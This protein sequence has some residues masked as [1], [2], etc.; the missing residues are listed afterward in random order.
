[1]EGGKSGAPR[2]F[3]A[4]AWLCALMLLVGVIPLYAISIYSHPHY[5]DYGF[6][7]NVHQAWQDTGNVLTLLKTAAESAA[8]VRQTWQG[9]YLGT[10][11]SNVQP[12]VFSESLYFLTTFILLTAFLLCFGYFFYTVLKVLFHAE[13]Y[14]ILCVAS[15]AMFLMLQLMPQI[16]EGLYWFN[17]G[18]GN[19]FVY[20]LIALSLALMIRLWFANG[21]RVWRLTAALALLM[22]ALGGGSY[23]GGLFLLCIGAM[24]ILFAFWKKHK[25]RFVVLGLFLVLAAGFLYSM[26]APGNDARAGIMGSRIS[27]PEAVLKSMYYGVTLLGSYLTLPVLAVMLFAVPLFWELAGKSSF[28]FKRPLAVLALGIGLFCTQLAPPIYSGV[29][30]GGGRIQNTY[31]FSFI[32]MILL[33]ELYLLGYL[34]KKLEK[35]FAFTEKMKRGIAVLAAFLFVFGVLGFSRTTDGTFG[36]KNLTGVEAAVSIFSGE[37]QAYDAAMDAREALLNDP[38]LPYVVLAP[39]TSTPKTFMADTLSSDMTVSILR[40]LTLYYR[41]QSVTLQAQE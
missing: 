17:G 41:K 22:A 24:V 26:S 40:T 37:A 15:L 25:L 8:N 11:L 20:S 33:Y 16:N 38:S 21:A 34:R 2:T 13:F 5:D 27:A 30:I 12:G 3:K 35:P 10:I 18:I 32:V 6:S 29:F 9:T 31:Y 28:C 7:R 1:M 19:T 36:P 23:G 39:L 4:I 14:M